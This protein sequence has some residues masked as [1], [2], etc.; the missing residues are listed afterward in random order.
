M[1][2]ATPASFSSMPAGA[3]KRACDGFLKNAGGEASDFV[4][5][6]VWNR[7]KP[8]LGGHPEDRI[9]RA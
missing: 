2:I 7:P 8:K 3:G 1:D 9:P 6:Q 5:K 4:K